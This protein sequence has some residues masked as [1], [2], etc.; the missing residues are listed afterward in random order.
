MKGGFQKHVENKSVPMKVESE[1][2]GVHILELDERFQALKQSRVDL[3][4]RHE[5]LKFSEIHLLLK[6]E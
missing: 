1:E 3:Q 4:C 6:T 5:I 2:T